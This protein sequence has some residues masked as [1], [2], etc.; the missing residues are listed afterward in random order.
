MSFR[1]LS[2]DGRVWKGLLLY[3]RRP[4]FKPVLL[5][6]VVL[7]L[8]MLVDFCCL[9]SRTGWWSMELIVRSGL[10]TY[11]PAIFG[12]FCFGMGVFAY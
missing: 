3:V 9:V 12:R 11:Y 7:V 5:N 10:V 4:G 6:L 2:W 1:L 8:L